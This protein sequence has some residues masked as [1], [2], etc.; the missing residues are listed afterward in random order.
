MPLLETY[1]AIHQDTS[2]YLF[3]SLRHPFVNE[4]K[5]AKPFEIRENRVLFP[6]DVRIEQ[7]PFF[8]SLIRCMRP[9]LLQLAVTK[10]SARI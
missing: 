5:E 10:V 3:S 6:T 1:Q 7:S 4:R 2:I 9:A 8:V